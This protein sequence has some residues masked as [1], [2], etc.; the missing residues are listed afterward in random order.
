MVACRKTNHPGSLF[1]PG[2]RSSAY[3]WVLRKSTWRRS[4]TCISHAVSTRWKRALLAPPRSLDDD[5]ADDGE[6][7]AQR[8]TSSSWWHGSER[9]RT[10]G[11]F[12]ALQQHE[13]V[14]QRSQRRQCK[15]D[16][17][18][19]RLTSAAQRRERLGSDV[20]RA[21]A[22]RRWRTQRRYAAISAASLQVLRE[23]SDGQ[24]RSAVRGSAPA[25]GAEGA[26]A[27]ANAT[28]TGRHLATPPT[29]GHQHHQQHSGWQ[30]AQPQ[31]CECRLS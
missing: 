2:A 3:L 18:C 11:T 13:H 17:R 8:Q 31:P 14:R 4:S 24:L 30:R 27:T 28:S 29:V 26:A 19:S 12:T 25:K 1:R 20:L 21:S 7:H 22:R 23:L 5:D 9:V 15:H 10:R 6:H 16:W